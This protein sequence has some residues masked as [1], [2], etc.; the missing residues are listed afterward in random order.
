MQKPS[1]REHLLM[2]AALYLTVAMALYVM[3]VRP[4]AKERARVESQAELF[5]QRLAAAEWPR[6]GG[7]PERLA[8]TRNALQAEVARAR[9][10]L[11]EAEARFVSHADPRAGDELRLEISALAERHRVFFKENRSCTPAMLRAFVGESR[12][13]DGLVRFLALG[14]PYA[15]STR[16]LTLETDFAGLR[17]FLRD[18]GELE[19]LVIVLRFE[20]TVIDPGRP[21]AAP[22]QA[23]LVV[24]F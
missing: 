9:R 21:G 12:T 22:L 19:Q 17:G 6:R 16:Q 15:L 24:A 11:D 1:R 13:N 2:I 7:D 3:K 14:E 23:K 5:R 18:L 4:A 8:E 20:I 10:A